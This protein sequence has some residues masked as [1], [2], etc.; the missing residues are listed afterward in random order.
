[1]TLCSESVRSFFVCTVDF[2]HDLRCEIL[3]CQRLVIVPVKHLDAVGLA[4][5]ILASVARFIPSVAFGT[6][7]EFNGFIVLFSLVFN[8]CIDGRDKDIQFL[9]KQEFR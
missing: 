7:E 1:M 8:G 6:S 2:R 4:A 5:H 3:I 9:L